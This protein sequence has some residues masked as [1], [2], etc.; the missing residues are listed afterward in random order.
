M[1]SINVKRGD[2]AK[3]LDAIACAVAH[4]NYSKGSADDE[5]INVSASAQDH[6]AKERKEST[7]MKGHFATP[8]V[9]NPASSEG[10][11]HSSS[12]EHLE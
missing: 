2:A 8:G 5:H 3:A 4:W 1:D 12:L 9:C 11:D 6:A 10:T 7:E